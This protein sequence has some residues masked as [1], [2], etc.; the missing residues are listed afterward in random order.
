MI[1]GV[2]IVD[3]QEIVVNVLDADLGLHAVELERFKSPA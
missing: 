2:Q 1:V 3:L